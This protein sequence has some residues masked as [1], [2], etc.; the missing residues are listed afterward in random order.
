MLNVLL[1]DYNF[2]QRKGLSTLI[3]DQLNESNA[4]EVCFLLPS[5]E[6][7]QNAADIIF[8]ND[9]VTIHVANK[10]SSRMI[11]E[12][13]GSCNSEKITIHIPFLLKN[14]SLSEIASK[15]EKILAVA[16][17]DYNILRKMKVSC[18]KLGLKK[19]TQLSDTENDIMILIGRGYDSADISRILNRSKKTIS[20]HYR[21]ASRKIGVSNRA[22]FYRY[23]SFIANCQREERNTL[24]L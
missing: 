3:F 2:Y 16:S 10:S 17:T 24:C 11:M 8:R 14:Q 1:M 4:E 21:N 13:S 7:N 5:D 18:C 6:R 22:E 20:T 12:N 15:I 23:A 19:Y 9:M